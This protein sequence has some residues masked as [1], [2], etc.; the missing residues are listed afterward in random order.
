MVF[1]LPVSLFSSSFELAGT[2][3]PYLYKLWIHLCA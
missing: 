3:H 1:L 2:I